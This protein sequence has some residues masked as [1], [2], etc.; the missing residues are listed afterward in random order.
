MLLSAACD[1]QDFKKTEEHRL[2]VIQAGTRHLSICAR[3]R[4][5]ATEENNGVSDVDSSPETGQSAASEQLRSGG[6]IQTR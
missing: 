4:D 1:Q 3:T 5:G 2:T 6:Q